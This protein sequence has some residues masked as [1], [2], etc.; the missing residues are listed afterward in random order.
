MFSLLI[1]YCYLRC[2]VSQ[3]Q[4]TS[5]GAFRLVVYNECC[6]AFTYASAFITSQ[7]TLQHHKTCFILT[8]GKLDFLW[9]S[10]NVRKVDRTFSTG[11]IVFAHNCKLTYELFL[12]V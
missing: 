11:A 12:A 9:I 7:F 6:P 10:E 2:G 4:L 1:K 8:F 5:E 3:K